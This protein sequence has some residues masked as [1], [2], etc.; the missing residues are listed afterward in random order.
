MATIA[1]CSKC[2]GSV[3]SNDAGGICPRCLMGLGMRQSGDPT[4]SGPGHTPFPIPHVE[5]L[6]GKFPNLQIEHY[7]GHG[8][9]GAV[10]QARQVALDRPVALKI[11]SPRLG[12]DP[13]FTERFAREARTLA[14]LAHPNIV[15]VFEHGQTENMN[16]LVM[17]FVDGINLRDAISE[18]KLSPQEALAIIPQICDALQY[19][20]DEGVIHRD[21]KPENILVDKKGRVKIAD[22]G[23]AKLL[24]PSGNE[25]TLTGTQQVMGTRNY[26]APE[27]I[28]SP[29]VVDH[30]ADLYSLGVVF[31]ELLTGEL[32]LGRFSLPSE[33]A[34]V[35]NHLDDIVLRTLEK[36]PGRRFQQ[37]SEIKSAVNSFA[38]ATAASEPVNPQF[39]RHAEP[40]PGFQ[41]HA[42]RR[43]SSF[44]RSVRCALPFSISELYG[45]LACAYGIAHLGDSGIELE[46]EVQ[47]E[48][49][50]TVKSGA[51][52]VRVPLEN[53]VSIEFVKGIFSDRVEIQT[54]RLEIAN[55]VPNS[56]QA[57][58]Q[59]GTKR[60]DADRARKFVAE[61]KRFAN[62]PAPVERHPAPPI[63]SNSPSNPLANSFANSGATNTNVAKSLKGPRIGYLVAA[64]I[65]L[66]IGIG[67]LL[68]GTEWK[69]I[70]DVL[71]K[72][73]WLPNIDFSFFALP[74]VS[75]SSLITL[76]FSVWMF[77][78][79]GKLKRQTDYYF[80]LVSAILLLAL[81]AHPAYALALI[82]SIWTLVALNDPQTKAAFRSEHWFVVKSDIDIGP[83]AQASI[84]SFLRTFL[85][86]FLVLA[87][88]LGSVAL[89]YFVFMFA[90]REDQGPGEKNV[91]T[92]VEAKEV[93]TAEAKQVTTVEVKGNVGAA[94]S[95]ASA[96][97]EQQHSD[98]GN[99]SGERNSAEESTNKSQQDEPD[100]EDSA[101]ATSSSSEENDN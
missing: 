80:V 92:T 60:A 94:E 101:S 16:Y 12:S 17:E 90:G 63:K 19:A 22:F 91:T 96:I 14:K 23:L 93:V 100:Q 20:H 71:V 97:A 15:M 44:N 58:F 40:Q 89:L 47:D 73:D 56:K 78:L 48:V 30:R 25:F 81:A 68:R 32:P 95:S 70:Q 83:G 76:A 34:K 46:Y 37:A 65:N 82:F 64:W 39:H 55:E 84:E 54:D 21:I 49:F 43:E 74:V 51:K 35:D 2:G 98:Q 99:Q 69:P 66:V 10:Y 28:E 26:M 11:L 50:G 41:P 88:C 4:I 31:Y 29:E 36:E 57:R 86:F 62:M 38:S 59:L 72:I 45:G 1:V 18:G 67:Q 27:Q 52:Q 3:A 79:A 33:K 9:M 8:G 13:T 87:S 53:I 77:V 75:W 6:V 85:L 42:S 24:V 61:V 7:I 5:E